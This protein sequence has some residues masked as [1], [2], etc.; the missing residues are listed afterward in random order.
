MAVTEK[1]GS[2]VRFRGRSVPTP[3]EIEVLI[4]R[5]KLGLKQK[6]TGR[7]EEEPGL[8]DKAR[9]FVIRF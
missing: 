7:R 6:M 5:V 3:E 1:R 2:G 8:T 9:H 4:D